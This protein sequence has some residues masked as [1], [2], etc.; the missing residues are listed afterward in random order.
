MDSAELRCR[1]TTD[2]TT[3]AATA[4]N[5]LCQFCIDSNQNCDVVR[6]CQTVTAASPCCSCSVLYARAPPT[7]CRTNEARNSAK[8]RYRQRVLV[9]RENP[10]TAADRPWGTG[11][12]LLRARVHVLRRFGIHGFGLRRTPVDTEKPSTR[13]TCPSGGTRIPSSRTSPRRIR[14]CAG[15]PPTARPTRRRG[16][17]ARR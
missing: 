13:R 9:Y 2:N 5:S 8:K 3:I 4:T 11:L 12:V 7:A 14:R 16:T 10:P 15:T 6:Y 1:S 17:S